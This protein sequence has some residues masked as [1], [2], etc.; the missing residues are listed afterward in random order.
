MPFEIRIG[1]KIISED[2]QP[3]IIAEAGVN[4]NQDMSIAR[5]LVDKALE[6]G[7]DCIKFQLF[8]PELL[9]TSRTE[10]ADYSKRN[11]GS[12]ESYIKLLKKLELG[13]EE[14]KLLKGYCDEKG[15]IFMSTAHCGE[16]SI[17]ALDR[18][19][20]PAHTIASVDLGNLPA[21]EY[22]A[23]KGKPII[24]STGMADL[25]EV[26]EA[27]QIILKHN[28]QLILLQCT[29]NYPAPKDKVN[30]RA[31]E[32][33]RQETGCLTG[34]S[35]H[36]E[37]IEAAIIAAC[38]GAVVIEKHFTLDRNMPGP[39]QAASTEPPEF[40]RLI[41]YIGFVHRSGIKDPYEAFRRINIEYD[42]NL[43][44]KRIETILGSKEKKPYEEEIEIAR[45][46]RKSIISARKIPKGKTIGSEDVIIKRPGTG[47]HPRELPNIVGR[48]AA[49]DIEADELITTEMLE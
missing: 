33:I 16:W 4:H 24:L 22:A 14:H 43:D 32:T 15:I 12:D 31:M 34:F 41:E 35:D 46:A 3:F 6:I 36:T 44:E 18:I 21:L 47:M 11:T 42:D 30:L 49:A 10:Q 48:K 8:K 9:V 17:D 23:R 45:I 26:R 13:E 7:A 5:K 25:S 40:M 2:K 38:L 39:D 28:R 37:G 27:S 20:V 19:G 1:S 29:T